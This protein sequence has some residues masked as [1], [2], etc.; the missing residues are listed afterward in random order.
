MNGL[1]NELLIQIASHL[2]GAPPSIRKFTHE[3]SAD[4][5]YSVDAPLKDLSR[6]SWKWRKIVLPI[7]F[8]YS[9]VELD[10]DPQW[11]PIDA[12]LIEAM[13]CQL[14]KLSDHEFQI[15]Q[16]MR[17][18]FKSNSTFRLGQA[19]DDPLI[20]LCRL[21]QGDNFLKFVPNILWIPHLSF[22]EFGRFVA[23]H[24]LKH[25]IKS[26]VVFTQKEYELRH[27]AAADALLG[28]QIFSVW[29][30]IFSGLEPTRLV[31]AAPPASLAAL[32]DTQM[33][34]AD[35]WAF[36]MK[37]HYI[38]LQYEPSQLDHMRTSDCRPWNLALIHRR[39][40]TYLGYNEGSSI[41]AFSVYEY[42]LKQSP[43]MLYLIL[44]RLAKEVQDCCNIRSFSFHGVFPF[45]TNVTIIVRALQKLKTLRK[46]QVQLAPGPENS[47][48]SS[49]KRIGRAQ[50]RDLWLEWNES[51]KVITGYLGLMEFEDGSEFISKDCNET[52]LAGE[53]DEH[54]QALQ[55]RGSGWRKEGNH[56]WVRDS[57]LDQNAPSLTELSNNGMRQ[58]SW[59]RKYLDSYN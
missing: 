20:N 27:V 15:Y 29:S 2:D 32:L 42:H 9:R 19:F 43:K 57:T 36:D 4:L 22:A 48:L 11:V 40:W 58:F 12:N 46:I 47:L 30:Q 34:S 38:E 14:S 21:Q 25:H 13:Q 31:V 53:V 17:S 44:V 10:N 23:R 24:N 51:Y 35:A 8:R 52:G 26:L 6:V 55:K 33:L 5:T 1:P 54:M 16:K 18:K 39:P 3:P 56:R 59:W 7:L 49:P 37:L 45:G 28:R 41:T 50:P